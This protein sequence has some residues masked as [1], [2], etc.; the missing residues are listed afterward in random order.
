M[1]KKVILFIICMVILVIFSSCGTMDSTDKLSEQSNTVADSSSQTD[2]KTDDVVLKSSYPKGIY[3]VGV[4]IPA[5]TYVVSKGEGA[6]F[7][8]KEQAENI[9][10][11]LNSGNEDEANEMTNKTAVQRFITNSD[12]KVFVSLKE[13]NTVVVTSEE[14][15]EFNAYDVNAFNILYS[16]VYTVGDDINSGKIDVYCTTEFFEVA[17][18]ESYDK[19]IDFIKEKA[20]AELVADS[21]RILNEYALSVTSIDYEESASLELKEGMVMFVNCYSSSE[22][23]VDED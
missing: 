10:N 21:I 3:Q 12:Y 13:G 8:D 14:V 5:G 16:G 19:Y 17:I 20:N 23:V 18:F 4:D 22:Y 9:L 11:I 15:C 2:A 6:V 7:T 1:Q